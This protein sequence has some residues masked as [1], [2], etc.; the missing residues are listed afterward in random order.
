MRQPGSLIGLWIVRTIGTP[1]SQDTL[2]ACVQKEL[3]VLAFSSAIRAGECLSALGAEGSPF[4]V[5]HA[6]VDRV[7]R[8]ARDSGARGFIVDYDASRARFSSAHP[9][10]SQGPV[11][12][13]R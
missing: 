1:P 10:P 4:Y 8:Q 3:Y 11:R 7:V 6:N 12:A 2:L 5:C 13:W 9:L